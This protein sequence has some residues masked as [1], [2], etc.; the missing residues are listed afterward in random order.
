M[1]RADRRLKN[2]SWMSVHQASLALQELAQRALVAYVRSIFLQPNKAVF[3]ASALPAAE[4]ALSMGLTSVP[5]LR[6]LKRHGPKKVPNG[7]GS[8]GDGESTPG[9]RLL[10]GHH[11]ESLSSAQQATGVSASDEG[12]S[13]PGSSSDEDEDEEVKRSRDYV[14]HK[15]P[16]QQR[17]TKRSRR[18]GHEDGRLESLAGHHTTGAGLLP[19]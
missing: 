14:L 6:F 9:E 3:D 4:F 1:E 10:P 13:E 12:S 16:Q 8:A 17:G 18:D 15:E 11:A 5:K 2:T 7:P 19:S